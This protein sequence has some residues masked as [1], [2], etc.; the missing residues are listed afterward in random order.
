MARQDDSS[1]SEVTVSKL[2]SLTQNDPQIRW[3][4]PVSVSGFL[5]VMKW[6]AFLSDSEQSDETLLISGPRLYDALATETRRSGLLWSLFGG[7][8]LYAGPATVWASGVCA[9]RVPQ[10]CVLLPNPVRLRFACRSVEGAAPC[11]PIDFELPQPTNSAS[12]VEILGRGELASLVRLEE[13][14]SPSM[15]IERLT[16]LADCYS[17][18]VD[19]HSKLRQQWEADRENPEKLE[20]SSLSGCIRE[21]LQSIFAEYEKFCRQHDVAIP[22][23]R[24]VENH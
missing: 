14:Y 23:Q 1:F 20:L 16:Y 6:C 3:G 5:R 21:M 13:R 24:P 11:E 19:L 2:I 9:L 12:S 4:W 15:L 18:L 8:V 10:L 22:Y 17:A 7:H